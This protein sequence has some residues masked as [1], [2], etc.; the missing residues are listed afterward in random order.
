MLSRLLN[1]IP[2]PGIDGLNH[3]IRLLFFMQVNHSWSHDPP[4]EVTIGGPCIISV[5]C[6]LGHSSEIPFFIFYFYPF[7]FRMNH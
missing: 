4:I 5:H 1:P 3:T 6:S 7:K 2:V